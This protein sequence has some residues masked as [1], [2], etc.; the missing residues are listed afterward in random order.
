MENLT[1]IIIV[2]SLAAVFLSLVVGLFFMAKQGKEARLRSNK[3]MRLRV[4]LQF[5]AVILV[6]LTMLATR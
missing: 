1:I 2:I 6:I 3:M 5:I 4:L